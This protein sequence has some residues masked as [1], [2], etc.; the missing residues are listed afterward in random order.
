M[1]KV[2]NAG[3]N[4]PNSHTIPKQKVSMEN[5]WWGI[6]HQNPDSWSTCDPMPR[7][8]K[9]T[10]TVAQQPK[11]PSPV[12]TGIRNFRRLV[13]SGGSE[14]LSALHESA[15]AEVQSLSHNDTDR[16]RD[17]PD[18]TSVDVRL[19]TDGSVI[20]SLDC[21]CSEDGKFSR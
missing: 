18:K 21:K 19:R 7:L 20:R 4:R 15:S 3:G 14:I 8:N 12:A 16:P 1:L 11:F 17:K 5:G 9:A 10:A 2:S 6:A 13:L